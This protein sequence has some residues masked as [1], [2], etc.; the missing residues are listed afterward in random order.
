MALFVITPVFDP[1]TKDNCCYQHYVHIESSNLSRSHFVFRG[2][3]L[4]IKI[5]YQTSSTASA[6]QWLTP[7]QTTGKEHPYFFTQCQVDHSD[8]SQVTHWA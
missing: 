4:H 8:W 2:S 7:E 6:A 1:Q 5:S 3:K